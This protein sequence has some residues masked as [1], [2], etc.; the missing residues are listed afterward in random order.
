MRGQFIAVLRALLM[1]LR[2]TNMQIPMHRDSTGEVGRPG[3]S[4]LG[5]HGQKRRISDSERYQ[6][7]AHKTS[8]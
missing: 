2:P 5:V 6:D 8:R 4:D 3:S 1:S 7:S